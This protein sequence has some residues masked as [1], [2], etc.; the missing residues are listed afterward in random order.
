MRPTLRQLQYVVAVAETGRFGDAATR[1][2]V[3][4]PSL[5]AQIADAEA[6][7]GVQLFERGRN[8][9]IT[10]PLGKDFVRRARAILSHMEDL[11]AAMVDGDKAMAGRIRLG[12]LPSIGPYLLP[13]AVKRLH[14]Q[15]PEFRMSVREDRTIDLKAALNDGA[16][17]TVISTAEDHQDANHTPLFKEQF[18]ICA[19]Q[20]D[21]LA[22]E[23]PVRPSDLKGRELLTVGYGYRF[24]LIVQQIADASRAQVSSEFQG[25]SLDAIRQMAAMGAGVAILP[26]LYASTEARR[27]PDLTLRPIDHPLAARMISLIWR[28]TSP[29][30]QQFETIASILKDVSTELLGDSA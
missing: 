6:L 7:L 28:P 19:A 13:M 4:Q 11:K 10:T 25:T 21:P 2:N 23:G 12:V 14:A 16:V 1:M 17:D 22:G 20:D 18:W 8:G 29:L 9:A 3:S 5:S 30:G 26:S 27:D 24:S 15:Y